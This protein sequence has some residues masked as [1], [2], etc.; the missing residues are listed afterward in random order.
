MKSVVILGAGGTAR[1]I[2]SFID[3]VNAITPTYHCLGLLDDR[4]ELQGQTVCGA[5][6]LGPLEMASKLAQQGVFV[7]DSLGS[8]ANFWKKELRLS[9]LNIPPERFE[10]LIHPSAQVSRLSAIGTGSILYPCV[11][12][13]SQAILGEHVIVLSHSIINHDVRLEPFVTVASGA[14]LSGSVQ[15]GQSSYIGSHSAVRE[16]VRIG[17]HCLVGMGSV[18]LHDV[19]DNS[20]VVGNPARFLRPTVP[21]PGL[22][23]A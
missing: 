18:V 20:V 3:D 14:A 1:D 13:L 4:P 16:Q 5:A 19:P 23:P 22:D 12:V 10:T 8:P 7:L 2:L 9:Q 11:V 17:R 6:V 21:L 15:V